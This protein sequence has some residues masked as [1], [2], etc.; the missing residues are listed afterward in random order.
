MINF[1]NDSLNKIWLNMEN[2]ILE[3]FVKN[4]NVL[5]S[6]WYKDPKQ[7]VEEDV[8]FQNYSKTT[9]KKNKEIEHSPLYINGD[10]IEYYKYIPEPYLGDP[11]NCSIVMLN[12]HPG[13]GGEAG[14]RPFHWKDGILVTDEICKDYYSYAKEFPYI[15]QDDNRHEGAK[16]WWQSR[17][18]WLDNF[19]EKVANAEASSAPFA[20]ELCPWHSKSW[21]DLKYKKDENLKDHISSN[22]I[23]PAIEAAKKAQVKFPVCIGKSFETILPLLGFDK[24]EYEWNTQSS[25]TLEV[26]PS[27][28]MDGH[29]LQRTYQLFKNVKNEYILNIW[30]PGANKTP[31]QF[32]NDAEIV[33]VNKIKEII[34]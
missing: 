20:I 18:V 2:E 17:K 8:Y 32:F 3:Q 12:L 23:D 13:F 22:V 5:I 25:D 7:R 16:R 24:T 4:N 26:W 31:S 30:A 6:E 29:K 9:R 19:V 27:D 11:Y 34:K 14:D 1:A 21:K 28:L 15:K 10:G 33:I